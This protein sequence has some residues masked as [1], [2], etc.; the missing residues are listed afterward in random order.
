MPR[1][2]SLGAKIPRLVDRLDGRNLDMTLQMLNGQG[3]S[4]FADVG[5]DLLRLTAK[6]H[7]YTGRFLNYPHTVPPHMVKEGRKNSTVGPTWI[8][9]IAD[10]V[11]IRRVNIRIPRHPGAVGMLIHSAFSNPPDKAF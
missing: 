10:V 11:Q 8:T 7:S 1:R 3:A 9:Y 2:G 5:R 4:H 6:H